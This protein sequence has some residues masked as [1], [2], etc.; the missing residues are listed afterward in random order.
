MQLL[1]TVLIGAVAISAWTGGWR[2]ERIESNSM[3]PVVSR[4]DG[5]LVR[6]VS[7]SAV[8]VGDVIVFAN[9]ADRRIRVLHRVGA[10]IQQN[11]Q[12]FFQTKGDA[13]DT[14]DHSYVPAADVQGRLVIGLPHLGSVIGLLQ[15]PA[16]IVLLV[17]L[18]LVLQGVGAVR[19]ARREVVRR[20]AV[21]A[22]D[23]YSLL[24][25]C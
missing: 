13:N 3:R 1:P 14:P 2:V 20:T 22:E 19:R 8:D 24:G 21:V 7:S 6:P 23:V 9:P 12:R 5:V 4:G 15:P 16:G 17:L 11:G 25:R 18:P 10:V